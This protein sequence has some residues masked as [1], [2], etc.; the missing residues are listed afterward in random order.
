MSG[1]TAIFSYSTSDTEDFDLKGRGI[2]NNKIVFVDITDNLTIDAANASTYNG[3]LWRLNNAAAKTVTLASDLPVGF[4][5][6]HKQIGAGAF[7]IAGGS[8]MTSQ[9]AGSKTKTNGQYSV[10]GGFVDAAGKF[11]LVGDITT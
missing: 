5:W 1:V 10:G 9:T 8:G 3:K 7:T 2:F 11:T 6:G 4:N